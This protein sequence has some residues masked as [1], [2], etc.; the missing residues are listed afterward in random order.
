ML[1]PPDSTFLSG[2]YLTLQELVQLLFY[3]TVRGQ[4]PSH[5]DFVHLRASNS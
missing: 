4:G 1:R 5:L 3:N 2:A